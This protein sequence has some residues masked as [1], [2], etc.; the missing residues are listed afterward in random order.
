MDG[1]FLK[2]L[3]VYMEDIHYN[4]KVLFITKTVQVTNAAYCAMSQSYLGLGKNIRI[5]EINT[6][7]DP[8]YG[9]HFVTGW[10]VDTNGTLYVYFDGSI[11]AVVDLMITYRKI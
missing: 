1:V 6:I 10:G 2:Q 11:N 5:I 9:Y 3:S 7:R 8:S 4:E